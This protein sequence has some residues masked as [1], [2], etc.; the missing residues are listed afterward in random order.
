MDS[1]TLMFKQYA[2]VL[3]QRVEAIERFKKLG[4]ELRETFV[5]PEAMLAKRK[6]I[7]ALMVLGFPKSEREAIEMK[8][9]TKK[10]DPSEVGDILR[11][12]QKHAKLK[13][14]RLWSRVFRYAFPEAGKK[15]A[16]SM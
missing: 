4:L 1:E 11:Q 13:L 15:P 7:K 10:K 12:K 3:K 2:E 5:V 14:E 9:P 8:V 6:E 16:H